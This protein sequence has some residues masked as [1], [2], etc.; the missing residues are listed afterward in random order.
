[1]NPTR[2]LAISRA[3]VALALLLA[4]VALAAAE[5]QSS[6]A[7][8]TSEPRVIG[9]RDRDQRGVTIG[10]DG[11]A[12]A[13][14]SAGEMAGELRTPDSSAADLTYVKDSPRKA[15][16]IVGSRDRDRQGFLVNADGVIIG[17]GTWNQ[18]VK[19]THHDVRTYRSEPEAVA[20]APQ[21]GSVTVVYYSSTADQPDGAVGEEESS[22]AF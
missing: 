19:L 7:T 8:Q 6:P 1:M 21:Q 5:D 12:M 20:A 10:T 18:V 11:K 22:R 15:I 17:W 14:G 2:H 16:R 13:W 3:A 4:P 9:M